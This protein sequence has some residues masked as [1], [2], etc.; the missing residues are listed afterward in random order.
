VQFSKGKKYKGTSAKKNHANRRG[1]YIMNRN[2]PIANLLSDLPTTKGAETLEKIL[3]GGNFRLERI[4]SNGQCS[5]EGFW[6]DQDHDEWVLLLRGAARIRIEGE[7]NDRVLQAGDHLLLR[8]HQRH[9]VEWT[10]PTQATIWLAL[11]F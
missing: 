7:A 4:I 9:R 5:P 3:T 2:L 1:D 6:Y 11:H 8:A 10:D